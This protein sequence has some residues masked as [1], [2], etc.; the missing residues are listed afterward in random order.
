MMSRAT[1]RAHASQ[2][3]RYARAAAMNWQGCLSRH[4]N[5]DAP[6]GAL[7]LTFM[8]SDSRRHLT[9]SFSS[10]LQDFDMEI[11]ESSAATGSQ[12]STGL[13][14]PHPAGRQRRQ[15]AGSSGSKVGHQV[16]ASCS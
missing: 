2:R 1:Q 15:A 11:H 7:A 8:H 13:F 16:A 12:W 9:S 14:R 3:S 4:G 5:G 6:A 10:P